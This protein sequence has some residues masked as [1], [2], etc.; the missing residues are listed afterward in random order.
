MTDD[1]ARESAAAMAVLHPMIEA[2]KR[3]YRQRNPVDARAFEDMRDLWSEML[4]AWRAPG[5]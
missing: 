1:V 3:G 4:R 5:A 2:A